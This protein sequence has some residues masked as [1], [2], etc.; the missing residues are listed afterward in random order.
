MKEISGLEPL[1]ASA[2][3]VKSRAIKVFGLIIV[4]ALV[5][6]GS[7]QLG[8]LYSANGLANVQSALRLIGQSEMSQAQLLDVIGSKNILGYWAGPE[9]N[10]KYL[11]DTSEINQVVLTIIPVGFNRSTRNSHPQITT[12][13]QKDAFVQVL[14]GGGNPDVKGFI[15]TDGNAVF[16]TFGDPK[17]AYV[18]FRG[19]DIQVQI[20]DPVNGES[21]KIATE[22]GR[23]RPIALGAN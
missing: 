16:Y 13:I 2:G 11:L 21:L 19:K 23:L 20:Y 12:Y 14:N 4:A 10:V 18:G 17:N 15:N 6:P 7:V 1:P 3:N 9:V 5:I 22:A 8:H